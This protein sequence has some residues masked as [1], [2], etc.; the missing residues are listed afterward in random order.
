MCM[1]IINLC[2]MDLNA[3]KSEKNLQF[4]SCGFS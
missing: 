3:L 1:Y 2:L 4:G